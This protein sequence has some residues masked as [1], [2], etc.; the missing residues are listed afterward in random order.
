MINLEMQIQSLLIS[1]VYG[2]FVAFLYNY[3]YKFIYYKKKWLRLPFSLIFCLDATFLFFILM[4]KI[5]Y[6]LIHLYFI[7]SVILGFF[8]GVVKTKSIR[9]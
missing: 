8:L 5:N 7:L 3:H 2:M 9:K 1:F 4:L 6:G